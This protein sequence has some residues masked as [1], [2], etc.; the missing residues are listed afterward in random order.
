MC[1]IGGVVAVKGKFPKKNATKLWDN[2]SSRGKHACGV[3]WFWNDSDY[4]Q[5]WKGPISSTK[6]ISR[7]IMKRVGE[8]VHYALFHTRFATNGSTKNNGNN[9]PIIRDN[10][11][12]THNGVIRNHNEV[13]TE[14]NV[15]R[16]NEVD[17]E[18]LN[19]ALRHCGIEYIADNI[20]GSVSIAWV[21][22]QE[23][24]HKI[25][26]FT[27]GLNPLVIGRTTQN[28]I[29]WASLLS[30]LD[31]FELKSH[32]YAV[33][34][35]KYTIDVLEGTID[36]EYVSDKRAN[37]QILEYAY[38]GENLN[39][40]RSRPKTQKPKPK[41]VS[42]PK[43]RLIEGGYVYDDFDRV[44]RKATLEDWLENSE[45]IWWD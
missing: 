4:V 43:Q 26:L 34:Y 10:I 36:S 28:Q 2:I 20:Q 17:S 39:P 29:V 42:M 22:T 24:L 27:N 32:F 1:G 14:F 33:P 41:S 25:N 18:A 13:F 8:L 23:S 3:S 45:E 7:G 15:N 44:W 5:T 12:L 38:T 9:H 6:A 19:V 21:D 16:N 37:P 31:C 40:S 30:H 35:K 11:I